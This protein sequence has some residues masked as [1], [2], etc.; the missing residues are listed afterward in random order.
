MEI[1]ITKISSKGQIVIPAE[2]RENLSEGDKLLVIQNE[3]QFILKKADTI[4][5]NFK[6]DIEFAMRT[7]E[8]FK[9]YLKG[10][11]IKMDFDKFIEKAKKW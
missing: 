8:A 6:E 4:S 9:K 10:E 11:F 3:N 1:A 2:M 7:E 5:K